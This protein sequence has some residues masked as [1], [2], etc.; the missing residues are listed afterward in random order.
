MLHTMVTIY[1]VEAQDLQQ[2][3]FGTSGAK[4]CILSFYVRSNKTVVS[5]SCF[6]K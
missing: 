1:L 2:L 4:D 5:C 6:A 3:A